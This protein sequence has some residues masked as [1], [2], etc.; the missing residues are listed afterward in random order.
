ML[1]KLFVTVDNYVLAKRFGA[2]RNELTGEWFV[3]GEVPTELINLT[4]PPA[5]RTRDPERP[6]ACPVCGALTVKRFRKFDKLPF[7]GCPMFHSKNCPGI[8]SYDDY[9]ER[10]NADA[11]SIAG[12]LASTAKPETPTPASAPTKP[13]SSDA[14]KQAIREIVALAEVQLGARKIN[15]WF[16]R[17]MA[18]LANKTPLEEMRNLAG[19]ER[20]KNLLA[21]IYD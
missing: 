18:S 12:A 20:V 17:R 9:L 15:E 11:M 13:E 1:T 19:C 2:E 10:V 7:W 16:A 14:L 6:P 5:P 8:V 4:V 3:H 21:H